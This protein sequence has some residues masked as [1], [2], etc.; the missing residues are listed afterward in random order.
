M[1]FGHTHVLHIKGFKISK[2]PFPEGEM[3]HRGYGFR[4]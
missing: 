4:C 1:L 2:E 3:E